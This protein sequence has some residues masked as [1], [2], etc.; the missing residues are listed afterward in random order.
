M[1]AEANHV[2][3]KGA[4]LRI[5]SRGSVLVNASHATG[6]SP[7]WHAVLLDFGRI[8]PKDIDPDQPSEPPTTRFAGI[9]WVRITIVYEPDVRPVPAGRTTLGNPG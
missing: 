3:G 7:S 2:R 9:W 6:E 8:D 5:D 4:K 1:A